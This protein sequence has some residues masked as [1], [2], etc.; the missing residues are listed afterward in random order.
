[1]ND[2]ELPYSPEDF[3]NPEELVALPGYVRPM[4]EVLEEA[5]KR[6]AVYYGGNFA[7]IEPNK[8]DDDVIIVIL[9]RH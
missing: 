6:T 4:D 1:M 5:K 2:D 3:M 7:I 8:P 9:R